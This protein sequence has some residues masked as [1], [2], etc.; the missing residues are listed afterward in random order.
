MLTF[1]ELSSRQDNLFDDKLNA[2]QC[3]VIQHIS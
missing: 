1:S 3:L 2:G